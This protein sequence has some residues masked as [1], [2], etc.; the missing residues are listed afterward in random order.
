MK[1]LT[2]YRHIYMRTDP[3]FTVREAMAAYCRYVRETIF[4]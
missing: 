1:V 3:A 4:E 2:Y